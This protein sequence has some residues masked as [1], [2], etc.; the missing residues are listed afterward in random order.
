VVAL[1]RAAAESMWLVRRAL[2]ARPGRLVPLLL[3]GWL[4]TGC[5][6]HSVD[7]NPKAPIDVPDGFGEQGKAKS[8]DPGRWWKGFGDPDLDR[9][10]ELAL[11]GNLQL[12]QAW[13]RLEQ[14][15]A[16]ASMASA[17]LWPTVD[18][19]AS[20]SRSHSAPR[21]MSFGGREQEISGVT[22]DSFSAS[23]PMSYEL[24]LW[25]R[26]RSGMF[27]ADEDVMA[28]R[29]DVETAA[30]TI[31]ANVAERWFDVI[32]TR[33]ARKLLDR[34]RKINDTYLELV[35]MRFDQADAS[36]AEIYLQQQQ[37]QSLDAQLEL[38]V[39]QGQTADLQLAVLIGKPPGSVVGTQ[40]ED[41]PNLPRVPAVGVPA[42]LLQRRPDL[43]AAR[44]RAVAADY[45]LGEAIA[46]RFP[47][48]A[49]SGSLGFSAPDVA[50]FFES[51]VWNFMGSMSASIWDGGRRAAEVNRNEAVVK[52]RI[53]AYGQTLLTALLEV[54]S[55]LTLERSQGRNIDVLRRQ[56]DTAQRALDAAR[57][58]YRS[59]LGNFLP[60][61][62]ALRSLRLAEQN[63]LTANRQLL[64]HRVQLYRALG[65]RW[66][67]Q[68]EPPDDDPTESDDEDDE[69]KEEDA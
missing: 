54:E 30:T 9:L 5:L 59:G 48:F 33:A 49:L 3:A 22:S 57:R 31:A 27:A 23:L 8:A 44:H 19:Q 2:R 39:A 42:Q 50:S 34:Q 62:T 28:M 18:A 60:V 14:A 29:A 7:Q 55:S 43:R 12:K 58:R 52:E 41:L 66:T 64:S 68:L 11:E 20:Y 15:D 45:R 6:V 21:V 4:V 69:E 35:E 37:V 26:V 40:R 24:D 47:T 17:G 63:L 25:G 46:A 36:L 1:Q 53:Y 32:Q 10:I 67:E 56:A 61:L 51:F 65:S 13:A 16:L 38:L